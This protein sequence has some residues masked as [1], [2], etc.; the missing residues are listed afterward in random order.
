[1]YRTRPRLSRSSSVFR[2]S[3]RAENATSIRLGTIIPDAA[4][5]LLA[6]VFNACA[7]SC[8]CNTAATA[9]SSSG[10]GG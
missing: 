7:A 9:C 2:E 10:A 4:M 5:A 6:T 8:I 1:M 3:L